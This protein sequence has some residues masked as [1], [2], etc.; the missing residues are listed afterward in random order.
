MKKLKTLLLFILSALSVQVF[1]QNHPATY[2]LEPNAQGEIEYYDFVEEFPILKGVG[3]EALEDEHTAYHC[4]QTKLM[5][6]LAKTY[7]YPSVCGVGTH[8]NAKI[9]MRY[10]ITKKGKMTNI[11]IIKSTTGFAILDK[12][13]LKAMHQIAERYEWIPG[14]ENG[15]T[16]NVRMVVP[17]RLD[18]LGYCKEK[19]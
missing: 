18:I 6:I 11:E 2:K 19:Y 12:N 7:K 10:I 14:K 16:V 1:A 9:F 4:S 15:K 17:M 5:T 8:I 13:A 3:C